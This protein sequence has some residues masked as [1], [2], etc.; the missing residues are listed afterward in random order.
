MEMMDDEVLK[1]RYAA[2]LKSVAGE[3]I[4]SSA[5][6]HW[7]SN[8]GETS[9]FTTPWANITRVQY[10]EPAKQAGKAGIKLDLSTG[11]KSN[12]MFMLQGTDKAEQLEVLRVV[13]REQMSGKLAESNVNAQS[14]HSSLSS[15]TSTST[16]NKKRKSQDMLDSHGDNSQ[17]SAILASRR[18]E[19]LQSDST[20]AKHHRELCGGIAGTA[21]LTEEEFW[22]AHMPEY[23]TELNRQDT[24]DYG[25]RGRLP[26]KSR[27]A[28]D[29]KGSKLKLTKDDIEQILEEDPMIARAY[30]DLVPHQKSTTEFWQLYI[31]KY[32]HRT[33]RSGQ[34]DQLFAR[35]ERKVQ[36]KSSGS[37]SSGSVNA[38]VASNSG[39]SKNSGQMRNEH[40]SMNLLDT[41]ADS[42]HPE[43]L[44][45]EDIC[46]SFGDSM[47]K[48]VQDSR[49]IVKT[50]SGAGTMTTS[51][52]T[53]SGDVH[54]TSSQRGDENSI[55]ELQVVVKPAYLPLN[56]KSVLPDEAK[57]KDEVPKKAAT[58]GFGKIAA[59]SSGGGFGKVT[60]GAYRPGGKIRTEAKVA[61]PS[62]ESLLLNLETAIIPTADSANSFL[63]NAY[64]FIKSTSDNTRKKQ[65]SAIMAALEMQR[66]VEAY[67]TD[68][69]AANAAA[70]EDDAAS[71]MD[72]TQAKY[73]SSL[74]SEF[75]QEMQETFTAIVEYLRHLYSLINRTS[76][77]A[78]A[79]QVRIDTKVKKI[80]ER[81]DLV[82]QKIASKKTKYRTNTSMGL[83]SSEKE[84]IVKVIDEQDRLIM[85][86]KT[87][88][89]AV[90]AI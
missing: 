72:L 62:S 40:D 64:S 17:R 77:N 39:S 10:C 25:Q 18:E 52:N 53:S 41:Y 45:A 84:G 70:D 29:G 13:V 31:D 71:M 81:L 59:A 6:L 19:L 23:A 28:A 5:R 30:A 16:S 74:P 42:E 26:L 65:K 22:E 73:G 12:V 37:S 78:S 56:L 24:D 79:D 34:A 48:V 46:H 1:F 66:D 68:V 4:V 83:S 14:A 47:Q 80:L 21:I 87:V 85:R 8:S 61:I 51:S 2:N 76:T 33:T 38:G 44:D 86:A 57:V 50:G 60:V 58:G 9:D 36:P 27:L 54:K 90:T 20:L 3:L 88:A 32:Y 35:Y 82:H 11:T 75:K 89:S 15:S 49:I 67:G 7:S 69:N 55:I 63:E 43:R